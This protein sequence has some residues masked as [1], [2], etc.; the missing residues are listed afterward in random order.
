MQNTVLLENIRTAL[1]YTPNRQQSLVIEAL[2]RFCAPLVPPPPSDDNDS[3]FASQ[4]DAQYA[5][6]VDFA[7]QG[8]STDYAFILAGYAGTGKTSLTGALVKALNTAGVK[9]VLLAPTGRAA[10]VFS[11]YAK[12]PAYTI[13]RR[14]Y[15]HSLDGAFPGL[16]E[17][18]LDG[19][20]FIV[21]E[22][23]MISG[24]PGLAGTNSLLEDLIQYVFA[25][26]GNRLILLG[27]TAQLPTVGCDSSPAMDPEVLRTYGLRVSRARLTATVRQAA[28]SGIL[29]NATS[30]RHAMAEGNISI[31]PN[32][33]IGDFDDTKLIGP[34]DLP[35][36][37]DTAYRRDGIENCLLI[38]RSNQ[39]A[40]AFNRAIRSEVLYHESIIVPGEQILIAKNNYHWSRSQKKLDF[41]ANGDIA[42]VAEVYG[43]EQRYGFTFADVA[44]SFPDH[45]VRLD[46]KLILDTLGSDTPAL[47]YEQSQRLY[48]ELL[49]DDTQHDTYDYELRARKV[50]TNPYW[51]ALQVKYAYAVTCHKA[52]GGQW[53]NVFVDMGYIAPEAAGLELYRWLYTAITRARKRLAIIDTRPD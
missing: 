21:D 49:A 34:E 50:R 1:P 3:A 53:D 15:R 40:A 7:T 14:I 6:R 32:I 48:N 23:S 39:R 51:N 45:E 33:A 52:Q 44:L 22:A 26:I 13:H 12:S 11:A 30:L 8:V 46:C 27:D 4:A 36:E 20:V 31:V 10:K 17:N 41:I 29:Y 18:R 35:E 38:T 25:G 19:A 42:L 28:D 5:V 43:T 16:Q 24:E 9:T 47:S 2:A 37:L